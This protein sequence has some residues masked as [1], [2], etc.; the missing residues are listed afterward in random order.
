MP[1]AEAV[2]STYKKVLAIAQPKRFKPA[3]ELT[4]ALLTI[5]D[6]RRTPRRFDIF[7]QHPRQLQHQSLGF[8]ATWSGQYDAVPLRGIR[9]LLPG[10]AP[11]SGCLTEIGSANPA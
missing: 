5:G 7:G 6:T 2:H 4:R 8:A 3:C 1:Q 9:G 10:I 11:E